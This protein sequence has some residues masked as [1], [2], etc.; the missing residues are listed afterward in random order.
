VTLT[1]PGRVGEKVPLFN[2]SKQLGN[3]ALT[4]QK[5]GLF[6]R[7]SHNWRGD[8]LQALGNAAGLD[9]F[10]RG[11]QSYDLLASYKL[12]KRW[13]L[14]LEGTN[15]TAAPEEQYVGTSAR[16]LYFG[17]T[18]RSYSFGLTWNY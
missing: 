5:S 11:F 7:V 1:E 10:A 8:Y 6:V 4:Y 15:L 12:S 14:R 17:D 16:N 18:G 13:T 3:L 9:Q 2:Q